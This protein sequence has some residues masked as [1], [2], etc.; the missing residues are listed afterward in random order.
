MKPRNATR[1]AVQVALIVILAWGSCVALDQQE[2]DWI[3]ANAVALDSVELTD[4]HDD[5]LPLA[6][7]FDG[8][9]VVGIGEGTHGTSEFFTFRLRLIEFLTLELGYT[10]HT[11]EFPYG[12]GR[13]IDHYVQTGEGSPSDVLARVYCTPWNHQ[14]MLDTIEWMRG[15][16]LSCESSQRVG[17]YGVDIHDGN[18]SLLIDPILNLISVANPAKA[19]EYKERLDRLRCSSMYDASALV[20]P[21]ETKHTGLQWVIDDLTSN[22]LHYE[23]AA[24]SSQYSEILHGAELLLQRVEM[25]TLAAENSMQGN[26]L[27]DE[28]MAQNVLWVLE[29]LELNS[30]LTFSGHNYHVGRFKDLPSQIPGQS[31]GLTS[32]GWHLGEIL[33]IEYVVLGTT[34]RT[35]EVAIFPYPGAVSNQFSIAPIPRLPSSSYGSLLATVGIG[36]FVLDLRTEGQD[37]SSTNWMSAEKPLLHIGTSFHTGNPGSYMIR[38]PLIPVLDLLAY[39]ERTSPPSM[40]PWIP[41][42]DLD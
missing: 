13:L 27:R 17:F 41:K 7:A 12:E 15:H 23:E 6:E 40:F 10:A 28:F 1:M 14:E 34:T 3:V 16:N 22:R 25:Y 30:G 9:R 31:L 24:P 33:G 20:D 5:L 11:F 36:S 2:I 18:S 38:T 32:A 37:S 29:S 42:G 26:L 4:C 19:D 39:I 21:G 8:A 35:G